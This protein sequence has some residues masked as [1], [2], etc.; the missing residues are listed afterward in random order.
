MKIVELFG[1]DGVNI[2]ITN[3]ET[4]VLNKFRDKNEIYR[5][6]LS[7]REAVIANN[8]VIKNL[9]HRKNDNGKILYKKKKTKE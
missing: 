9:L 8:L 1:C 3:E 7:E 5:K 2:A 6:E 4:D